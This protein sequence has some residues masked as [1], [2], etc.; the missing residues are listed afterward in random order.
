MKKKTTKHDEH[1]EKWQMEK[2]KC[3]HFCLCLSCFVVFFFMTG[4]EPQ[5]SGKGT[6]PK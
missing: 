4:F 3:G 2:P 5:V 1:R 6:K